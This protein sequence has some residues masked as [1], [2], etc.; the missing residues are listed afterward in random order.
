MLSQKY[1]AS[2]ALDSSRLIG[3]ILSWL[4]LF[5]IDN[6]SSERYTSRKRGIVKND[7]VTL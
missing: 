3:L 2:V 6:N 4:Y 1:L 5:S 7:L